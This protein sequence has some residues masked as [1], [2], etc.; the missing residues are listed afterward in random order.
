MFSKA[1][2]RF[3]SARGYLRR[4]GSLRGLGIEPDHLVVDVGSGQDPHPRANVL[5][6]KYVEDSTERASHAGLRADRPLIIADA[7]NTP[8]PAK[9]FDFAFCAHLL[10]HMAD[11]AALLSE[12]ERIAGAGYIETPSKIYEKL[13]GWS[14]HRWFVSIEDERLV[15]EA[16]DRPIFDGDLHEW[17]GRRLEAP[18]FWRAFIPRLIENELLTVFVW[19][20]SIV[21]RIDGVA[22]ADF[23]EARLDGEAAAVGGLG[24]D[25]DPTLP[26]RMKSRIDAARRSRSDRRLP[27][28]LESLECVVC[29]TVVSRAGDESVCP[30]CGRRYPVRGDLP[31]FL[32]EEARTEATAQPRGR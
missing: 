20:G 27:A 21:H 22:A 7:T 23:T 3:A 16:K 31:V 29:R 32:A 17:F 19:R 6:D 24:T 28:L 30:G 13:Y 1:Y 9:A 10:E 18:P 11:P 12:L 26:Q 14:F 4:H 8:F 2:A 25:T 5:C 15:L